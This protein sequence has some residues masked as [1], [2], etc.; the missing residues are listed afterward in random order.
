LALLGLML[1]GFTSSASDSAERLQ[2]GDT[3]SDSHLARCHSQGKH[4][5]SDWWPVESSA[6]KLQS[7]PKL[8]CYRMVLKI[9]V[10][11]FIS[12]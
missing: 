4:S 9:A 12:N 11:Y 6:G 3:Y 8:Y 2:D 10:F 7:L 5:H 1:S